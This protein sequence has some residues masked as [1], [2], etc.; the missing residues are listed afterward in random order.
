MY[1]ICQSF[2]TKP[3]NDLVKNGGGEWP[4]GGGAAVVVVRC[5][6]ACRFHAIVLQCAAQRGA[7]S[8][9]VLT[10]HSTIVRK[11]SC[12]R[13]IRSVGP[14]AAVHAPRPVQ[15]RAADGGGGG[16]VLRTR[17]AKQS[18]AAPTPVTLR[19]QYGS[20]KDNCQSKKSNR[21]IKTIGRVWAWSKWCD[22]TSFLFEVT[23]NF[24]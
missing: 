24:E 15:R 4:G 9:L 2:W 10:L 12:Q 3:S 17:R 11:L 13:N 16:C 23:M 18:T 14:S 21:P 20:R 7:L 22:L 5:K 8:Q 6:G 1:Y 19:T